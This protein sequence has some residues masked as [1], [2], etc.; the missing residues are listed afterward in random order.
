MGPPRPAPSP[1]SESPKIK[2]FSCVSRA[3]HESENLTFN[4]V[5]PALSWGIGRTAQALFH[6]RKYRAYNPVPIALT[7]LMAIIDPPSRENGER[8]PRIISFS[9]RRRT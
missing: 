4:E 3:R 8:V 5:K 6:S 9:R 1:E 2:E 7:Y